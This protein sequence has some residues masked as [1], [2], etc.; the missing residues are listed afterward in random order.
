MTDFVKAMTVALL[1]A[2]PTA[3]FANAGGATAGA[4]GDVAQ[5]QTPPTIDS[6]GDGRPDAWDGNGDGKAD[7]WDRNGDG[8]PDAWDRNGDGQPDA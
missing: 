5:A 6:D 4:P 2:A 8:Q 3:A 1:V 7:A